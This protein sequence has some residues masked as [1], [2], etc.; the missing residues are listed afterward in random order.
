MIGVKAIGTY[1]P[2]RKIEN[3]TKLK[4]HHITEDFLFDKIGI[5]AVSRKE[6]MEST[7]DLCIR[8]FENLLNSKDDAGSLDVDC[9][10]VCTQNGDYRLPQTSAILQARLGIA[11]ECATFDISLGCSG[12]IYSLQIMKTF[13]EFN[14][15][16]Q[17]LLFTCDPYSRIIDPN[18]K[19]TDLLFGDAATVTLLEKNPTFY[20]GKGVYDTDGENHTALIK[21]EDEYL[22]MDGRRIFNFVLRSA[23][24]NIRKCLK[25]N[26]V[27]IEEVDLFLFHQASK[28]LIDNL[29]RR[30]KLESEKVPFAI[31]NYG[32]TVS[33][34]IPI[35][36]KDYLDHEQ[37]EKMILCGF[38][39]GLSIG[40]LVLRRS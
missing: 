26:N 5:Y 25:A 18:D 17:G 27:E 19:N 1:I 16:K 40:S 4:T 28:Y 3:R 8:A 34:S 37:I 13:M 14:G 30:M 2:K 7:S 15:L 29:V 20:I 10:C 32:N 38:G 35:V 23:P 11:S 36:L 31:H 21:K 24:P 12:Y 39:V 22:Y 33:S 9:V 6:E